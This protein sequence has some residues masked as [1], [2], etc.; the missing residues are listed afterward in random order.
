MQFQSFKMSVFKLLSEGLPGGS[1]RFEI[2]SYQRPYRWDTECQ[3]LWDDIK[4]VFNEKVDEYFLGSIVA[5]KNEKTGALEIIDG[6]Q[7]IS[8]FTLLFRAFYE[9]LKSEDKE[10]KSDYETDFGKCIWDY[11]R[12]KGLLEDTR[13]L[14][15][16]VATN[17]DKEVLKKILSK[18]FELTEED[19][20]STYAKNYDFFFKEIVNFYKSN[21]VS[22]PSFYELL[23]GNNL[24]VLLLVCDDQE[25]ALTIFDTL[26]SRGLPLAHSDLIKNQI[27]RKLESEQAKKNFTDLWK[28]IEAKVGDSEEVK[29]FDFLFTQYMYVVRGKN[30]DRKNTT[31]GVLNFFTKTSKESLHDPATMPFIENLADFWL[32]P[33]E[34][35]NDSAYAYLSVLNLFQNDAWKGFVSAL[36]WRN[37]ECFAAEDFDKEKFSVE[38][39]QYLPIFVRTLTLAFL[40]GN[41][42][43]SAVRNLTVTACAELLEKN[44]VAVPDISAVPTKDEFLVKVN[45]EFDSR[46]IK[47]L[48]FL[49]ACIYSK[50]ATDINPDNK[51]LEIEHILPKAWQNANFGDWNEETHKEYLEQIGNKILLDKA[52]NV[53]CA[54]KFFAKKQETYA[55]SHLPEVKDLGS[56]EKNTWDKADIELRNAAIYKR[57]KD[58]LESGECRDSWK[59]LIAGFKAAKVSS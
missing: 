55:K 56:R 18:K 46:K 12:D 40:R 47:Y 11:Q 1:A 10:K 49:D 37:K 31:P 32:A 7:R 25:S 54:E 57:L 22:P 5:F 35:L 45:K 30:G 27:Y 36:V 53:K 9:S 50:F 6:Q 59:E 41:A 2:P 19:M 3:T 28:D 33:K 43:T 4:Y 29:G 26:N 42:S 44:N 15:T 51:K 14:S 58:F 13:H 21:P 24:F 16:Q 17:A 39:L 38:F 48:L 23:L 8:T 52:S 20:K 34:Y